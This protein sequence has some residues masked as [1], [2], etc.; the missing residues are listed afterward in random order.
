MLNL[1]FGSPV[2]A[3]GQIYVIILIARA[4]SSW[5][6]L[7]PN[8]GFVPVVRF[9]HAVTEP[10]LAPFRKVIPPAGMF[11]LSFIVAIL[12]IQILVQVICAQGI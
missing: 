12:V 11:D 4:I 9:L 3:I 8:S 7:S 6:P 2:C 5:F 10:V 1:S